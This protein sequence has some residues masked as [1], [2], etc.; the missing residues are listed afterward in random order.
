MTN[1]ADCGLLSM[2]EVVPM[3]WGVEGKR[4]TEGHRGLSTAHV[5]ATALGEQTKQFAA[6]LVPHDAGKTAA[7]PSQAAAGAASTR[8]GG[9]VVC[10]DAPQR[11]DGPGV[12]TG[13]LQR[14]ERV[15][16]RTD[17]FSGLGVVGQPGHSPG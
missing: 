5:N 10:K 13:L 7:A 1:N 8:G 15:P 2:G 14:G 9:L 12:V 11:G 16:H 4:R 17:Q 6:N 3:V